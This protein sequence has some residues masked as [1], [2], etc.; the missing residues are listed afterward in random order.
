[1]IFDQILTN[2]LKKHYGKEVR[3]KN[4]EVKKGKKKTKMGRPRVGLNHQPFGLLEQ[5]NSRTR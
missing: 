3:T 1:M 2:K 4:K 5:I